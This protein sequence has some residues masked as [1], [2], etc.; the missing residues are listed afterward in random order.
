MRAVVVELVGALAGGRALIVYLITYKVGESLASGVWKLF[1]L[2]SGRGKPLIGLLTI[3]AMW[4]S[5]GGSVCGA[6]LA[7][8]LPLVTALWIPS[9]G[10][11]LPLALQAAVAWVPVSTPV[12]LAVSAAEN[13]FGGALTTV[14]FALMMSRVDARIGASHYT[15]LAAVE[16][17]GKYPGFWLSGILAGAM[18]YAP[19]FA[20]ATLLSAVVLLAIPPLRRQP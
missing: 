6:I 10:R 14:V 9:V 19:L 4:A 2:D 5:I 16:V 18:G 7:Q 1:L 8:R 17:A 15:A 20:L 11:L 3:I 13:F 12:I